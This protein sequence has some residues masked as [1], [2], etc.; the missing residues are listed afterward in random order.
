MEQHSLR[1]RIRPWR[2]HDDIVA[3]QWPPYDDPL[4]TLWNLPRQLSANSSQWSHGFE[5]SSMRRTW[6]VDDLRG[7]LIGRISLREID[8]RAGVARLG[9]TFGAPYVGQGLGTEALAAFLDGYFNDLNFRAMV[10]D[11]AAPNQRAVRC[12]RR[13]GFEVIGNDW[14]DAGYYFDASVLEWPCYAHLRQYF[15]FAQYGVWVQFF[16]MRLERSTW[17]ALRQEMRH[18]QHNS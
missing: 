9:I 6:A 10:L 15:R 16:E 14:R 11:V 8:E 7:Q 1:T 2:R 3:E 18:V 12:Y 13:L 5:V 17:L 4:D